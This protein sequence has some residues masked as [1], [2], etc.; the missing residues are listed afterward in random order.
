MPTDL[1]ISKG[2]LK[3]GQLAGKLVLLTGGGGGIGLESAR[4]LLWLGAKVV[5]AE[6]DR[7]RCEAAAKALENEVK[8][9]N[10]FVAEADISDE[11]SVAW[12]CRVVESKYGPV[13]VLFNNATVAPIGAV[14]TVGVAKWDL[15][16]RVNVRG[17]VLLLER[18][19]PGMLER[20]SGVVVLVPSSGAAPFMGAYETFKTAQVELCNTLAGELEGT[21]VIAFSIGPGIVKT[22][23]ADKAIRQIA[24]LYG[25]SVEEFY[26]MNA[27]VLLSPEEAGAGFAAAVAL[28]ERYN[29][30][31]TSSLQALA[32]A[33]ITGEVTATAAKTELSAER[34][35]LLRTALA[36][37]IATYKE[38]SDGWMA[39]NVFER[40]WIMRDF[41][42]ETGL[43]VEIMLECL[44]RYDTCLAN[45]E[46]PEE[47]PGNLATSKLKGYYQ[48]QKSMMLSYEKNK[49]KANENA[50]IIDGWIAE[51]DAFGRVFGD[52]DVAG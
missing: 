15:S 17:P 32:D 44:H 45:H 46:L 41:K 36:P 20:K 1:L 42:K 11:K 22:E 35:A 26:A 4:S 24:P 52:T 21:G 16:Y 5:I 14:H 38:Q 12:L 27:A 50:K 31:E 13:D 29:G 8:S 47:G 23:T 48:H 6:S 10:A 33:G 49:D 2:N 39:R 34:A 37:V 43:A 18:I 7:K 40:Q 30:M 28:A 51:I 9:G 3:E 19:L 25:K